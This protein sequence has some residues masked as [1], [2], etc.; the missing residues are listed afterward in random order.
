[1]A[2]Y[3]EL[4]QD[5]L[6]WSNRDIEVFGGGELTENRLIQRFFQY[7]ADEA[8]R[9]LKIPAIEW[10][11]TYDAIDTDNIFNNASIGRF[12]RLP[13]PANLTEFIQ[14]RK[15]DPNSLTG[16]VT[17][18]A[19]SDIQSFLNEFTYKYDDEF[20]FTREQNHLIVSYPEVGEVYELYYYGRLAA[21]HLTGTVVD[22]TVPENEQIVYNNWL[23]EENE[24][25]ILFGALAEAFDYL[26]EAEQSQKYR[27]KF[28]AEIETLNNEE[29]RRMSRGGNVQVHF[30]APLI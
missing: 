9:Q 10:L 28:I 11:H 23:V 30:I 18:Q 7:A 12:A 4:L 20:F 8:Y 29:T 14:L 6:D 19:K 3:N 21:L 1:M 17:Y 2:T 25:T 27:G 13:I 24:R 26:D 15:R 16:Y 22:D 5:F